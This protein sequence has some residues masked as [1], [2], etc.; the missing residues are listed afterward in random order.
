[1]MIICIGLG[2]RVQSFGGIFY[3]Q[4]IEET[5]KNAMLIVKAPYKAKLGTP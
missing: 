3:F 5:L 2:F 1:M 4:S